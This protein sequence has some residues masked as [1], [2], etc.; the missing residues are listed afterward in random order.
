[1][2]SFSLITAIVLAS[3]QCGRA[4]LL[5]S[6]GDTYTS[7]FSSLPFLDSI[8]PVPAGTPNSFSVSFVLDET[9]IQSGDSFLLEMLLDGNAYRSSLWA[10]GS[11]QNL[12]LAGSSFGGSVRF[13]GLSGSVIVDSL[14]M[15]S[16]LHASTIVPTLN[17]YGATIVPVPE[18]GP[19]VLGAVGVISLWFTRRKRRTPDMGC[20]PP[21]PR[22]GR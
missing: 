22:V 1:M 2:K 15:G 4:Q 17:H 3:C 12:S 14:R 13:T 5:L 10:P 9:S 19:A 16:Y 6:A 20:N 11:L 8:A 18:P 21:V 7:S